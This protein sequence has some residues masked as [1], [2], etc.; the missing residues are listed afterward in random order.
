MQILVQDQSVRRGDQLCVQGP[1]TG[2][3][4]FEAAELRRDRE[5]VERSD[6]GEWFTVRRPAPVREGDRV[7][8]LRP[9]GA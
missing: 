4:E 6:K 7:F 2:H 9:R 8:V 1:S 3:V 5:T